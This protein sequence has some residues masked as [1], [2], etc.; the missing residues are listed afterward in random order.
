MGFANLV[1][2]WVSWYFTAGRQRFV[3]NITTGFLLS[4]AGN[5]TKE[6]APTEA[7]AKRIITLRQKMR[8][9]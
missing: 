9:L 6:R 3:T 7:D 1:L 5:A 8:L 2:K 4:L